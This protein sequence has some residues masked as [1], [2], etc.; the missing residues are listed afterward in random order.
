MANIICYIVQFILDKIKIMT[1]IIGAI[2][3][4]IFY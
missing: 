4:L 3:K 2:Q 1:D